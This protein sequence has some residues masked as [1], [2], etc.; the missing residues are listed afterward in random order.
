VQVINSGPGA[1]TGGRAITVSGTSTGIVVQGGFAVNARSFVN[2]SSG[3]TNVTV[4]YDPKLT[5]PATGSPGGFRVVS[6]SAA[7]A[8]SRVR[9]A[10]TLE[11]FTTAGGSVAV[12]ADQVTHAI[13]NVTG[14]GNVTVALTEPFPGATITYVVTNTTAAAMGTVTWTGHTLAA[15]FVSPA[16]G[17]SATIT[18]V[19]DGTGWRETSRA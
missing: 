13:V 14:S 6:V 10:R 15:P 4:E 19:H 7:L 12:R 1:T 3:A 16:A 11:T 18:F 17:A 2:T 5:T 9:P 8:Q